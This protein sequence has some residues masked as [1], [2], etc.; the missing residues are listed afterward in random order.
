MITFYLL[1]SLFVFISWIIF[2]VSVL[3]NKVSKSKS[4]GIMAVAYVSHALSSQMIGLSYV[5]YLVF[6]IIFMLIHIMFKKKENTEQNQNQ[7]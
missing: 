2:L 5:F 1:T 4:Y 7:K 3:S 6:S